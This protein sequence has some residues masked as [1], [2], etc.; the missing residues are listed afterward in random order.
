MLEGPRET[1]LPGA[2][3]LQCHSTNASG[4]NI[5]LSVVSDMGVNAISTDVVNRKMGSV[6]AVGGVA[7]ISTRA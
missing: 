4:E 1:Q 3:E 6:G 7:I 2:T 5:G